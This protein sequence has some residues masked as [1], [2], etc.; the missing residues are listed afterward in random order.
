[1]LE[2]KFKEIRH[3]DQTTSPMLKTLKIVARGQTSAD[4]TPCAWPPPGIAAR[5]RVPSCGQR[6]TIVAAGRANS[7]PIHRIIL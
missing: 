3:D 1:L 6:E 2:I 5:R 4:G 7:H